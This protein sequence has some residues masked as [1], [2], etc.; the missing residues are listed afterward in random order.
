MDKM[1]LGGGRH[2]RGR[3][4]PPGDE[5]LSHTALLLGAMAEGHSLL[6]WLSPSLDMHTTWSCLMALGASITSTTSGEQTAVRGL[7]WRGL[8]QPK[9]CLKAGDSGATVR[10]LMGIIA[11][12]P[13]AADIIG[14]EG[15]RG[16][17]LS[18]AAEPLRKMGASIHLRGGGDTAPACVLGAALKGASHILP[19]PSGHV[20]AAILLAGT[21]ALGETSVTEPFASDARLEMLLERFGAKVRREGLTTTVTGGMNLAGQRLAVPPDL[22]WAAFWALAAG[23]VAGG[24][25]FIEGLTPEDARAGVLAAL[26]RMGFRPEWHACGLRVRG[27]RL[28]GADLPWELAS[29]DLPLLAL[30]ASQADGSS[31]L[32]GALSG[33]PARIAGLIAMLKEF[34]VRAAAEGQDL[35]VAGATRLKPG[36]CSV[37]EDEQMARAGLLAGILAGGETTVSQARVISDR[38]PGLLKELARLR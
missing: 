8:V 25:V 16:Y 20:K 36:L 19:R 21:M 30:A 32:R 22:S 2:L 17:P 38:Y 4:R 12:N 3:L 15:L 13:I 24:E 1:K 14:D 9:Q 37:G 11:A 5:T 34:G 27:M 26:L 7:G 18:E 28:C 23:L 31:R 35:M 10:L 29:V 33:S 6:E